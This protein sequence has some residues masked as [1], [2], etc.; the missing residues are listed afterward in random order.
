MPFYCYSLNGEVIEEMFP[1]GQAPEKIERD[2]KVYERDIVADHHDFRNANKANYPYES[3]ALGVPVHGIPERI[4]HLKRNG[5]KNPQ[6]N[7][8]TGA[9]VVTGRDQFIRAMK[10]CRMHDRD[11]YGRG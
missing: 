5:I 7:K 10:A 9:Y 6:F 4:E 11:S 8:R 1:L 3:M 2:G